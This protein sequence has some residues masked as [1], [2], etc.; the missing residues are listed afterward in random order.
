ML[1]GLVS[2]VLRRSLGQYVENIDNDKLSYSLYQGHVALNDLV[3]RPEA[4]THLLG[5]PIK[6][7]SGTISRVLLQIPITQLRSQPWCITIEGVQLLVSS[8]DGD[9]QDDHTAQNSDTV[10]TPEDK[11][12]RLWQAKKA[13]LDR[14]ESR[15][16]QIVQQGGMAGATAVASTGCPPDSSWWSY[17][18]SLVYGI[19]RN[20]QMSFTEAEPQHLLPPSQFSIHLKRQTTPEPLTLD[21]RI[22]VEASLAHLQLQL[23]NSAYRLICGFLTYLSRSFSATRR[24]RVRPSQQPKSWWLYAAGEVVPTLRSRLCSES[25]TKPVTN[26]SQLVTEASRA[27]NYVRTYEEHLLQGICLTNGCERPADDHCRVDLQPV[28]QSMQLERITLLR[29]LAMQRAA[30]RLCAYAMQHEGRM[31]VLEPDVGPASDVVSPVSAPCDPPSISSISWWPQ[32]LSSTNRTAAAVAETSVDGKATI[33]SAPTSTNTTSWRLWWWWNMTPPSTEGMNVSANAEAILEAPHEIGV[34]SAA[35][36]ATAVEV[37]PAEATEAA[38]G[39]LNELVSADD[40]AHVLFR[41][42]LFCRATLLVCQCHFTLTGNAISDAEPLLSITGENLHFGLETRPRHQSLR[43]TIGL[44]SLTIMDERRR[45]SATDPSYELRPLLPLVVAPQYST[46]SND[47]NRGLFW[48]AYELNPPGLASTSRYVSPFSVLTGAEATLKNSSDLGNLSEL[49]PSPFD[50]AF[51]FEGSDGPTKDLA[52]ANTYTAIVARTEA[53]LRAVIK[54]ADAE[55]ELIAPELSTDQ[56]EPV[57]LPVFKEYSQWLLDFDIAAPK[58]L[59]TDRLW[60]TYSSSREERASVLGVLCDFGHFHLSNKTAENPNEPKMTSPILRATISIDEEKTDEE[61]DFVTPCGSREPSDNEEEEDG[62]E[63][64]TNITKI[65]VPRRRPAQGPSRPKKFYETYTLRLDDLRVLAGRIG[66]LQR[67]GL[68]AEIDSSG[69]P[70]DSFHSRRTADHLISSPAIS[71]VHLIDRFSLTAWVARRVLPMA[72]ISSFKLDERRTIPPGIPPDLPGL[73]VSWEQHQCV[74]RLSDAKIDALRH[75]VSA[76]LSYSLPANEDSVISTLAASTAP[77]A[78]SLSPRFTSLRRRPRQQQD[79]WALRSQST[80][81]RRPCDVSPSLSSPSQPP[82]LVLRRRILITFRMQEL[83]LQMDSNDRPLAE[84]RLTSTTAGLARFT[85]TTGLVEYQ[86]RAQVHSLTIADAVS[87]LGGDFDLLAASHRGV[88][89]D[90]LSGH[91]KL[92][93][94]ANAPSQSARERKLAPAVPH[95]I[96]IL[97]PF[98]D[99]FAETADTTTTLIRVLY[100]LTRPPIDDPVRVIKSRLD[101]KFSCLDLLGNQ[102]TLCEL[103]SFFRRIVP[104]SHIDSTPRARGNSNS[105][106]EA[107]GDPSDSTSIPTFSH[108]QAAVESTTSSRPSTL[109]LFVSVERLSL[110][111]VRVPQYRWPRQAEYLAT[112]TLLGANFKWHHDA[113]DTY[114]VSLEGM[115]VLDLSPSSANH[116]HIFAAGS[117]LDPELGQSL[118]LTHMPPQEHVL[119]IHCERHRQRPVGLDESLTL[120]IE[121]A[122]PVY[123][124][125]PQAL[126]NIRSWFSSLPKIATLVARRLRQRLQS[127]AGRVARKVVLEDTGTRRGEKEEPKAL[128]PREESSAFHFTSFQLSLA[129]PVLVLP[130]S[131]ASPLVLVGRLS[132]LRMV[133]DLVARPV[134]RMSIERASLTSLDV[135]TLPSVWGTSEAV[136]AMLELAHFRGLVKSK[137]EFLVLEDISSNL[138]LS[139]CKSILPK[140]TASFSTP[141]KWPVD[142]DAESPEIP[143]LETENDA[144]PAPEPSSVADDSSREVTWLM[145]EAC[146]TQPLHVRLTKQVYQQ[147]LRSLDNLVAEEEPDSEETCE[148]NEVDQ[149]PLT[150]PTEEEENGEPPLS[151]ILG[152]RNNFQSSASED[153]L[154]ETIA[155]QKWRLPEKVPFL[156]MQFRMP[157]LVVETF[158]HVDVNP[159]GLACLTLTDFFIS[160][161]QSSGGLRRVN[162]HL[163]TLNLKNLLPDLPS[164]THTKQHGQSKRYLLFSQNQTAPSK[165]NR[166]RIVLTRRKCRY[167]RGLGWMVADSCPNLESLMTTENGELNRCPSANSRLSLTAEST[168]EPSMAKAEFFVSPHIREQFVRIRALY[169]DPKRLNFSTKYNSVGYFAYFMSKSYHT[170]NVLRCFPALASHTPNTFEKQNIC[171]HAHLFIKLNVLKVEPEQRRFVD[172]AFSSLT[173]RLSLHP[174]VLLLDFLG[175]ESP[176]SACDDFNRVPRTDNSIPSA[177]TSLA[178]T[179]EGLPTA[180]VGLQKE[181]E[182]EDAETEENAV[183]T[184]SV[185][186]FTLFLTVAPCAAGSTSKDTWELA[187]RPHETD[188]LQLSASSLLLHLVS[189]SRSVLNGGNWMTLDGK[190]GEVMVEDL[191]PSGRLYPQRFVTAPSVRKESITTANSVDTTCN[192]NSSSHSQ[193]CLLTFSLKRHTLPDP[194]LTRR[195]EEA[196]LFVR[197]AP[198]YYVHTQAFLTTVTDI[199]E[200]FLQYQ[201]LMNRVSA[202]SKGLKVRSVPPLSSRIRLDIDAH[203]PII[204]LPVCS[205]SEN[206]LVCDLGHLTAVNSFVWNGDPGS[207]SFSDSQETG[208]G[209]GG[210]PNPLPPGGSEH[211]AMTTSSMPIEHIMPTRN[212]KDCHHCIQGSLHSFSEVRTH[213]VSP[214]LNQ[215]HFS[216]DQSNAMPALFASKEAETATT[217]ASDALYM[218]CLLDCIDLNLTDIEIYVGRRCPQTQ[219]L[220]YGKSET[221]E[222]SGAKRVRTLC[223]RDFYISPLER[224]VSVAASQT[225]PWRRLTDP[226]EL[227]VRLE[228]NLSASRCRIAPDW[229]LSAKLQLLAV[230]VELADYTLLRGVL[231]HN[232]SEGSP[233]PPSPPEAAMKRSSIARS[234]TNAQ[235]LRIHKPW[236]VFA[237]NFDLQDVSIHLAVPPDWPSLRMRPTNGAG[238]CVNFC[239]L[240]FIRSKLAYEK[241]SD[242]L[243]N[244]ELSCSAVNFGDTRFADLAE[245]PPNLFTT[246]LTS[247]NPTEELTPAQYQPQLPQF[248]ITHVE[249]PNHSCMTYYLRSMRL[250][251][252]FDW[253]CDLHRFLTTPPDSAFQLD[254][255]TSKNNVSAQSVPSPPNAGRPASSETSELRLYADQSEFVLLENPSDMETNA[256]ILAGAACFFLR[257]STTPEE[258]IARAPDGLTA[259]QTTDSKRLGLR[260]HGVSVHTRCFSNPDSSSADAIVE[261]ADVDIQLGPELTASSHSAVSPNGAVGREMTSGVGAAHSFRST[262]LQ[263]LL[264]PRLVLK[265]STSSVR[266]HF[267]YTDS[268][269]FLALLSSLQEQASSAF[270]PTGACEPSQPVPS[271]TELD[272]SIAHL[273]GMGLSWE[274][275]SMQAKVL[276][277]DPQSALLNLMLPTGHNLSDCRTAPEK[278]PPPSSMAVRRLKQ[279]FDFFSPSVSVLHFKSNFSLCLID[280]CLDADVPLAE[281]ILSD[282]SA[283]WCLTGWAVGRGKA[284]LA[285][286][287]YNRDLSALEPAV[288]PFL[289]ILDWRLSSDQNSDLGVF[290]IHSAETVNINLTVPL[291]RLTRLVMEKTRQERAAILEAPAPRA[292]RRRVPFVPFRLSNQT[293]STLWF[294]ALTEASTSEAGVGLGTPCERDAEWL[295]V[296]A[297]A[298]PVDLPFRSAMAATP[299][300]RRSRTR[301]TTKQRQTSPRL[302]LLVAGWQPTYPVAVDRLGIFFRTIKLAPTHSTEASDLSGC[303]LPPRSTFTRLVIEVVRRGSAQNLIIVR[304]GLTVTN[305]LSSGFTL[306]LG[307]DPSHQQRLP[308]AWGGALAA[309]THVGPIS[310][311]D[312]PRGVIPALRVPF[313]ETAAVPLDLAARASLGFGRFC[314]RPVC[315]AAARKSYHFSWSELLPSR[316]PPRLE[317]QQSDRRPDRYTTMNGLN[318]LNLTKPADSMAVTSGL[319]RM[320]SDYFK[321][322]QQLPQSEDNVDDQQSQ[323]HQWQLC[324]T[325]VRDAFPP[326][327]LLAKGH[328]AA[329]VLPGHHFTVGP[330]L[331]IANLLPFDMVYFLEGCPIRGRIAPNRTASVFEIGC[332]DTL[333]FGVHLEGFERCEPLI[334]PPSAVS[335]QVLIKLIDAH[336]RPLELQVKVSS[337]AFG[338]RHLTVSAVCWLIN[339]SGLPLVFAQTAPSA[340]VTS[341]ELRPTSAAYRSLAAGQSAEQE[342]ARLASPLLFSFPNKDDDERLQVRIGVK[343]DPSG[344]QDVEGSDLWMPRWSPSINLNKTGVDLLSLRTKSTGDRPDLLYS[345]GV[346]VRKGRGPHSTTTMVTFT[347]RFMISN[348]TNLRLQFAQ[349]F[350]LDSATHKS[351]VMDTQ[352]HCNLSFHWPRQDLDQLLC[353]RAL[354]SDAFNYTSKDSYVTTHWSGGMQIDM[355]RSYSLKLRLPRRPTSSAST[356]AMLNGTFPDSLFLRVSIVLRSATF[357]VIVTDASRLPPLYRIENRSLVSLFYTQVIG[358]A[359]GDDMSPTEMPQSNW[360][361]DRNGHWSGGVVQCTLGPR[362]GVNYAPDEPLLPALL[363]VGVQGGL[364]RTYDFDKLGPGPRLVYEKYAYL[365]T[366]GAADDSASLYSTASFEYPVL[367]VTPRSKRV[368]LNL[369]RPGERSQ[370][371][372]FSD[373]GHILHEGS[374]VPCEPSSRERQHL[375][376]R[377]WV[378]DVDTSTPAADAIR[379]HRGFLVNDASFCVQAARDLDYRTHQSSCSSLQC[380]LGSSILVARPSRS[381]K[382]LV[383]KTLSAAKIMTAW[384]RR[385][386]GS[387]NVEVIADGPVKVLLISDSYEKPLPTTS[388]QSLLSNLSSGTLESNRTVSPTTLK[389]L[390]DF[391]AGLGISVVSGFAEELCYASFIGLR[392]SLDRIYPG[393]DTGFRTAST[394]TQASSGEFEFGEDLT[395][396]L[397]DA[398]FV[399]DASMEQSVAGKPSL[400]RLRMRTLEDSFGSDVRSPTEQ[401]RLHIHRIQ[402]DSQFPDATLPIL[403]FRSIP[404]SPQARGT[405]AHTLGSASHGIVQG[406]L[407]RQDLTW[408][409]GRELFRLLEAGDRPVEDETCSALAD[410]DTLWLAPVLIQRHIRLLNTGW[411]A[412]IF[413]LLEVNLNKLVIQAEETLLLKLIQFARNFYNDVQPLQTDFEDARYLD[414]IATKPSLFMGE[415]EGTYARQLSPPAVQTLDCFYFGRLR[416]FI[417]PMRVTVQTA[418]GKLGPEFHDVKRL[419]P[420]LMSFA[421]AELRLDPLERHHFLECGP[422]LLD[423]LLMHYQL[424]LRA[425]ALK[426]F[427]SVD[428]LGNPLGF[429]NDLSAGISGLVEMDVG[430]LVR[431]VFHGVGDS[432]AKVVGSMSQLVHAMSLDER[433][434]RQRSAILGSQDKN[435]SQLGEGGDVS[436]AIHQT[437]S[438]ATGLSEIFEDYELIDTA[439]GTVTNEDDGQQITAPLAAGFRGFV[440]GV[441]GG[442]TSMVTQPYHG[443]REDN[444]K[445]FVYGVGR[446]LLGTVAKPVGGVLDLVSGAMTTLREAAR[447]SSYGRPRRRRPRRAGL[448]LHRLPL[449]TYSLAA[450][451]SQLQLRRLATTSVYDPT[452]QTPVARSAPPRQALSALLAFTSSSMQSPHLIEGDPSEA[453]IRVLPCQSWAV[454]VLVTDR[455][456]WCIR[457]ESQGGAGQQETTSLMFVIPYR[458]LD[459]VRILDETEAALTHSRKLVGPG[460]TATFPPSSVPASSTY[461]EFMGDGWNKRRLL[462]FDRQ[463]WAL[464]VLNELNEAHFRFVQTAMT[465]SRKAQDEIEELRDHPLA[466]AFAPPLSIIDALSKC[467]Q[468]TNLSPLPDDSFQRP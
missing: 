404:P 272:E 152:L 297:Y 341:N 32:F 450:A 371:W 464:D 223:F 390:L 355:P 167:Q 144:P 438:H 61:D 249:N 268:Q 173:C 317:H 87:G 287:Y 366:C 150:D 111:L 119:K 239:R 290:E 250:I 16:W 189:H 398:V 306:E 185:T 136:R 126:Q 305:R 23:S 369:K 311:I 218:R 86:A 213:E 64:K 181:I 39:L 335:H 283:K 298:P 357:F 28:E 264:T 156:A 345:I 50:S 329:L 418:K 170:Y 321:S 2:A 103:I 47:E 463:D 114:D 9:E 73:L 231:A 46:T 265:V 88:R 236:Q 191:S 256:V 6:L 122:N 381:T 38:L 401:V 282:I 132:H 30:Q 131:S 139:K 361:S 117:C 85:G 271:P 387:L 112:A 205:E 107:P 284:R 62:G 204:V 444:F 263:E 330:A 180:S 74:L 427:G 55:D 4:L 165:A 280:D 75:C 389:V 422:Y 56:S 385:G 303:P 177:L 455:A 258:W 194:Q 365:T 63:D 81:R 25:G 174:W 257:R 172:V 92:T 67:S 327:P 260:L 316:P 315:V 192:F 373:T 312:V 253:L 244:T 458:R 211:Q 439:P 340:L 138:M 248:R 453:V 118:P 363:S 89:M 48:L 347:P 397:E 215:H 24:P 109:D 202:S 452:T 208:R 135:G 333:R 313:G 3:L 380:L 124:H 431:N 370:L 308:M 267:S 353:V 104:T 222:E 11:K 57:K 278:G 419:L 128:I 326:D 5:L 31:P 199:L 76:A 409:R 8:E 447:S 182:A 42:R 441:F 77:V 291:V 234:T 51:Q 414:L 71:R 274:Q 399:D 309:P 359:A 217:E 80:L 391:P 377:S 336:Q 393:T 169:V 412:Q 460:Q 310:P 285:V 193:N 106:D 175:F 246:I 425:Q 301:M 383:S 299:R 229:R 225:Q 372:Y 358:G 7:R 281:I 206:V 334:I 216:G 226:F 93:S 459:C 82:P 105:T 343:Y 10:E 294:K 384:L 54:N 392:L 466:M 230:H 96:S 155:A 245:S 276:R 210:G 162:A 212:L 184:L 468:P 228:R 382:C 325:V 360:Q 449:L 433:H 15:W 292:A 178:D 214:G 196:I 141:F 60:P 302:I 241:F 36:T 13:Y 364:S 97:S 395:K 163:A 434:Q 296:P 149:L 120:R 286:N 34:T 176:L 27:H 339:Q 346:E 113:S 72:V 378:L 407:T 349:R 237:F 44:R 242:D 251:L 227:R 83:I 224:T 374:S 247:I 14:L 200:R 436:E 396:A 356:A 17:G 293:G 198:A 289:C 255:C 331:R 53:N 445:G 116:R 154:G 415:V 352:P 240:D 168:K 375:S 243:R 121:I 101:V 379:N 143:F 151:A 26:L 446:G 421:D 342:F 266:T 133:S 413:T 40:V 314:V 137:S 49:P 386:S 183:L 235:P 59:F 108:L 33:A 219:M 147:V 376:K 322:Q 12:A 405:I 423:Q 443:V 279:I 37:P 402:V 18:V 252:A 254:Q 348:E 190:L 102:Q 164:Q 91:L 410:R 424:Q 261:P 84:C 110:V 153:K 288:E 406:R 408:I 233:T 269:L 403:L 338:A 148:C 351:A 394:D 220:A 262:G 388:T 320:A 98:F 420:K 130:Q 461:V 426:F 100:T 430:G 35:A 186:S 332:A 451:V 465:L 324:V 300:C 70:L 45:R 123:V 304:S 1:I 232:L 145:A 462:R 134:I 65:D 350:C 140:S 457:N 115:Q 20:L 411:D 161:S 238:G 69:A 417:A 440:H 142:F 157:L 277:G 318:W 328:E 456:L 187:N 66:D 428:F 307:L 166:S 221:S 429:I 179:S 337:R 207:L 125:K 94:D 354:V 201:D 368:V 273:M 21:P 95:P 19:I 437:N 416:I 454:S 344:G 319:R 129:Q 79:N 400:P 22:E 99:P 197:L 259:R 52:A 323:L 275:A 435:I 448:S 203:A 78:A 442:V 467:P 171:T 90:T 68:W 58:I 41:D 367:D 209:G 195:E 146:L 127:A 270:A 295:P 159:V 160:V 432:T 43:F 362:S 158:A 29:Q 188:F